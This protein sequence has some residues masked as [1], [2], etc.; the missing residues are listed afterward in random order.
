MAGS[1]V[2]MTVESIC[3]MKRAIARMS[4]AYRCTGGTWTAV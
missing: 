1:E 2:A 3:S 4:G